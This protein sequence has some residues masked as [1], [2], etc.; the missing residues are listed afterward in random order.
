MDKKIV[1]ILKYI[2]WGGVAVV[3]LYFS[4][5]SVQWSDF[6]AALAACRWGWV[7]VSMLLGAL[8]LY[9]RGLR[10][11]MQLLPIDPST[12]ALTCWNAYNICMIVNLVLPRAGEVVRCGY[13]TKHS[14]RDSRGNRLAGMDKVFGTV[15]MDRIWDALSLVVVL[16]VLLSLMWNRF[17]TFFEENIFQGLSGKAGLAWILAGLVALGAGVV[18]LSWRLRDKGHVWG[19]I[20]GI[21]KGLGD[22]LSSC[23]HMRQGWLF[24]VYTAVIWGL[25]WLMCATIMWSLQGISPEGLSPEMAASLEKIN[26]LG[27]ADALFLMFAGALSSLVPVPGG[28]G[29]FH[30]VVAGALLSIYGIPFPVGL[31][32]ATLSHESQV[33]TD[34]ICGAASYAWETLHE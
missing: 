28:F 19:R 22:G 15:V 23:L 13:V 12:R 2:L 29:A 3:L 11:R 26:T 5:R 32:F 6:A 17:G 27:M 16:A 24:I 10:W 14:A 34:A 30:T 20:W 18:W 31:I 1:N 21:F 8:V 9:V 7:V 25:Y 33:V 4:F